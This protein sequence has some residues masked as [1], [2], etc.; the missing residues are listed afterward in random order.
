MY[1]RSHCQTPISL[2]SSVVQVAA[3]RHDRGLALGRGNG[4][5]ALRRVP[6]GTQVALTR[7]GLA[8]REAE[9]GRSAASHR[10]RRSRRGRRAGARVG[11]AEDGVIDGRRRTGAGL[12][13]AQATSV[14]P[15]R[16]RSAAPRRE[17]IRQIRE[18]IDPCPRLERIV[19]RLAR[20][21]QRGAGELAGVAV[22]DQLPRRL[23]RDFSLPVGIVEHAE[24]LAHLDAGARR[25]DV[26]IGGGQVGG[27]RRPWIRR[28]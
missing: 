6:G 3:E 21:R 9:A 13:A 25:N 11:V 24:P 23:R 17:R 5:H 27:S 18:R 7:A 1:S 2:R 16:S 28:R 4:Q 15:G 14:A 12:H 20:D 8:Q 22:G 26:A 10:R 19:A